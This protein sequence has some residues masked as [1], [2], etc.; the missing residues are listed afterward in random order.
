MYYNGYLFNSRQTSEP[1]AL[2]VP[3][4]SGAYDNFSAFPYGISHYPVVYQTPLAVSSGPEDHGSSQTS[5]MSRLRGQCKKSSGRWTDSETK[6]LI[7]HACYKAYA[8]ALNKAKSLQRKKTIWEE[9]N[10]KFMEMCTENE[11]VSE[12]SLMQLKE[13]WKSLFD[14]YNNITTRRRLEEVARSLSS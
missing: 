6:T 14:R 8:N 10:A 3:G 11:I 4:P 13:K 5:A 9:I 1:S 2:H 12:K 7:M